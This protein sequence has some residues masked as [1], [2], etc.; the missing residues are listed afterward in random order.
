MTITEALAEIKTVQKRINK[1]QEFIQAYLLRQEQFKDP[2]E[3]D[4]GCR[5]V[6]GKERQAIADLE[7]RI[8]DLRL[9]INAANEE[10]VLSVNG[11][12]KSIAEWIVWRREVAPGAQNFLRKLNATIQS[13]RQE[14]MRRG[15][16]VVQDEGAA[17][18]EDVIVNVDE[19]TLATEI[20]GMEEVLGI[21]DGQLSLKNATTAISV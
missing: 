19:S 2:L 3:G 11:V 1:K 7:Q 16:T 17:G 21:L 14:A 15:V 6:V 5:V 18:S 9:A 8:V 12:E 13:A 4:G 10:T 20:E